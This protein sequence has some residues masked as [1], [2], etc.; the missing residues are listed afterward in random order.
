VEAA[1]ALSEQE[2]I[3]SCGLPFV[4]VISEWRSPPVDLLAPIV[5][6]NATNGQE[7]IDW[8]TQK[9]DGQ[10]RAAISVAAMNILGE[11]R[12]G[13]ETAAVEQ[14]FVGWKSVIAQYGT[15]DSIA[16]DMPSLIK[17]LPL[18]KEIHELRCMLEVNPLGFAVSCSPIHPAKEK[19]D[20]T[21]QEEIQD[22]LIR[23]LSLS[24][25]KESR[26]CPKLM[27]TS[28]VFFA[29]YQA[30]LQQAEQLKTEVFKDQTLEWLKLKPFSQGAK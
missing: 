9:A 10:P 20:L 18:L 7:L 3:A 27:E 4:E 2:L 29:K 1:R 12:I 19:I 11:W 5:R 17:L 22:G 14:R 28:R 24:K 13:D 16:E 26:Y 30:A 15:F 23:N 25:C 21:W 6:D 8:V